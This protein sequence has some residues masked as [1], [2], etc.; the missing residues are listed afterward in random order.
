[1]F[2]MGFIMIINFIYS[3]SNIYLVKQVYFSLFFFNI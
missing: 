1:M 2:I 3:K